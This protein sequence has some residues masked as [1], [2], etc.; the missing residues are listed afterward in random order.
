[1]DAGFSTPRTRAATGYA[2][3]A[4]Q[5]AATDRADQVNQILDIEVQRHREAP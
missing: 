3:G 4:A 1:M 2:V 5:A